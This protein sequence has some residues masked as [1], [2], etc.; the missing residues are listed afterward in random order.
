MLSDIK[1]S[2]SLLFWEPGEGIQ[3]RRKIQKCNYLANVNIKAF[4][5]ARS[6]PSLPNRN[7]TDPLYSLSVLTMKNIP[8]SRTE[9]A[10]GTVTEVL[11]G[12]LPV[13]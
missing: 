10:E 7:S 1:S 3:K 6:H 4:N 5:Y 12:F 13:I 11:S 9:G 2:T 8:A